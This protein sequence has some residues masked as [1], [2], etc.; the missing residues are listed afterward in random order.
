LAVL[1][2]FAVDCITSYLVDVLLCIVYILFGISDVLEQSQ[3]VYQQHGL[4][5]RIWRRNSRGGNLGLTPRFKYDTN[6]IQRDMHSVRATIL[7]Q[8]Y[9]RLIL[10]GWKSHDNGEPF[11][12]SEQN[13]TNWILHNTIQPQQYGNLLHSIENRTAVA[14]S[15]GSYL[16]NQKAGS[17]RWVLEDDTQSIQIL[18]SSACPGAPEVQC[19]HRSE[20]TGLL[21]II[22][23]VNALCQQHNI[24]QGQITIGCNGK[25]A[26]QSSISHIHCT[27]SYK[28]FDLIS[29]IQSSIA[30]SKIKWNFQHIKGHQDDILQYE[31]LTR[32]EQFNVATDH[33]AKTELTNMLSNPNWERRRPQN[34]PYEHVE[35]FWK[36][37]SNSSIKISSCLTKTLTTKIQ[38]QAIRQYWKKKSKFSDHNESQIDWIT[39][40]KSRKGLPTYRQRWLSKWMTGFCGTGKMLKIYRFQ[41]HSKCPRCQTDNENTNHVLQCNHSEALTLWNTSLT[42]LEEWMLSNNGHPELVELIILGLTKWHNNEIFPLTYDI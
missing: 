20:L 28:H 27:L 11:I 39:S 26:I 38:T 6:G 1:L 37:Q 22:T 34:L 4:I 29:S 42:S 8:G 13:N 21:G 18:G 2:W 10:T 3:L 15:D 17:A 23:H 5:W 32:M 25:G 9:N 36:N 35:V 41:K 7:Q 16:E 12:F 31:E 40:Q 24:N 14:V 33:M 19:S 30:H